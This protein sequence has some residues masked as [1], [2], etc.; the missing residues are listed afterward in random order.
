MLSNEFQRSEQM[1]DLVARGK[2]NKFWDGFTEIQKFEAL[3]R[4]NNISYDLR[5]EDGGETIICKSK[6][7]KHIGTVRENCFS[8]GSVMDL[9]EVFGLY[10]KNDLFIYQ[11]AQEALFLILKSLTA[12]QMRNPHIIERV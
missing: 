2:L 3:I 12:Y 11:T 6:N 5:V 10:N 8:D 7:G 1:W 9:V 4:R